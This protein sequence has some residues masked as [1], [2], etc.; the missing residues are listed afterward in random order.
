MTKR[1]LFCL[2]EHKGDSD[3]CPVC[4]GQTGEIAAGINGAFDWEK[5]RAL[6]E[7]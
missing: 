7:G 4:G 2:E 3:C 6:R 5:F 1:C